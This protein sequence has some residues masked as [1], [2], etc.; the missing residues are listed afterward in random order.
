M[1][2]SGTGGAIDYYYKSFG[3]YPSTGEILSN[4][5][6]ALVYIKKKYFLRADNLKG[7]TQDRLGFIVELNYDEKDLSLF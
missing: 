2:L 4:G 6:D 5:S 3:H 7:E 1:A